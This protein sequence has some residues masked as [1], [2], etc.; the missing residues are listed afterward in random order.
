MKRPIFLL[1][2]L[3]AAHLLRAQTNITSTNPLAEQ[4]MLGTYN[5]ATYTPVTILN[6]PDTIARGINTRVSPDSLHAYLEVLRTFKN[7]NTGSDTI[8]T[9]KGIGAARRWVYSKFQQFGPPG[10][11]LIPSYLQFNLAI[12]G[13]SQ[14]R[15][16]FAVLPGLDTSDK[17]IVVIEG[18]IDSRCA[19]LCDTAC[20]AEGMEDN[21]SGTALVME[22]ARVMSRYSYNHTIV[23]LIVIGEEQGLYGG[24]AFADYAVQ[25]G[26]P[27]RATFNDDV[28]GGIICGK[29]SSPPGCPGLNN[30]DSTHVRLFSFGGF[31]SPH[32]GLAR[33]VKL[34]YAEMIK[35]Y[36][37][38]PMVWRTRPTAPASSGGC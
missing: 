28:I 3:V 21:G 8:S 1:V 30:I 2:F 16:I 11:R 17:S 15:N 33:F 9:T 35:P 19:G 26:I 14:H 23:F 13:Q 32:K 7:R 12:C 37:V 24:K 36:A 25:K 18:H 6:N 38:V 34:E 4:I 20:L 27:V 10:G 29:T 22:L 31:N 5:P